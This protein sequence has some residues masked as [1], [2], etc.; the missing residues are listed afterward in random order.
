[1][2]RD[3]GSLWT[4][5]REWLPTDVHVKDKFIV[6]STGS[7]RDSALGIYNFFN[8]P[9]IVVESTFV[10]GRSSA[11]PTRQLLDSAGHAD[12][13][14]AANDSGIS[15]EVCGSGDEPFTDWQISELIRLGRW[16]HQVHGIRQQVVPTP[17]GG[18]YGWHIMFGSPGPWTTVRKVCPGEKRIAQLQGVIFPAIFAG[19]QPD[20]AEVEM[21]LIRNS[22]GTINV[23][24]DNFSE[25]VSTNQDNAA[26]QAK[27]G[28]PVQLSDE[29]FDR[30]TKAARA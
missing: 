1:M 29:L 3:P 21:I 6:H 19:A 2:A 7:V 10:V 30:L 13:N 25:W 9:D 8:R 17:T 15:V 4:P 26:L 12:A 27:L 5:L 11:D 16:A 28:K 23:L 18:G 20:S 22:K 14:V 24:G